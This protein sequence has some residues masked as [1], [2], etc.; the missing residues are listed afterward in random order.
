LRAIVEEE[1]RK[2]PLTI[3]ELSSE[4]KVGDFNMAVNGQKN[5]LRLQVTIYPACVH[6]Q[7]KRIEDVKW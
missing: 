2:R 4:T 1:R 6:K 7:T 3:S 5:V